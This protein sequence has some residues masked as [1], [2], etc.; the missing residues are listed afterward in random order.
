MTDTCPI[1]RTAGDNE[2][3]SAREMMFGTRDRFDYAECSHCGTLRLLN[4][5]DLRDYYPADYY[6]LRSDEPHH[7]DKFRRRIAA[8]L[9]GKYLIRGSGKLGAFLAHKKPTITDKFPKWLLDHPAPISFDSSVL[10]FGCGTGKLL[11]TLNAFGFRRLT[12]VDPYIERDLHYSS[13]DIYKRDLTEIDVVF[14]M[15]MLHHSF[16]H[17]PNPEESLL[18]MRRLLSASGTLLIR[19]P[20]VNLAWEK[21]GV[22]WVQLDPPRHLFLYTE[23]AFKLLA[24]RV[25]FEVVK[26]LYDSEA[27]QFYGSEQYSMDIP[28]NDPRSFRGISDTSI[29]SRRQ[30]DEWERMA[31]ELNESGL[32]DQACF[33]L[34]RIRDQNAEPES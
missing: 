8:R 20:V 27:F 30:Y 32:G 17:M 25:G 22:N 33:Y 19:I 34:K 21:Y 3:H 15:I 10:D 12:G 14:D 1:C 31:V 16:E 9:I 23:K 2:V 26:V 18:Q 29:F 13:I 5:P 11:R 24:K 7:F 6:S 28:M 4:V